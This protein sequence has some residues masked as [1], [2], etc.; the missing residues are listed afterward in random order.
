MSRT[1]IKV[2]GGGIAKLKNEVLVVSA[3]GQTS[4][5]LDGHPTMPHL[6]TMVVNSLTY[7]QPK[8][9]VL[10]G[11]EVRWKNRDFQLDTQDA[12]ALCFYEERR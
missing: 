9:F 2:P 10:K 8:Y 11:R 5:Q 4:F 7:A 6:A 3:D 12:V 1:V